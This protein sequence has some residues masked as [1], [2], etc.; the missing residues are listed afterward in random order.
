LFA[1]FVAAALSYRA[2]DR[3]PVELTRNSERA[4]RRETAPAG[5]AR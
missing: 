1:A 2:A 5:A 4:S 3:L